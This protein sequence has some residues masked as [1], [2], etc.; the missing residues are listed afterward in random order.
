MC[1]YLRWAP[2]FIKDFTGLLFNLVSFSDQ[3]LFHTLN[4]HY[5]AAISTKIL[6]LLVA[7]FLIGLLSLKIFHYPK[8]VLQFFNIISFIL[9][10]V[11]LM[12]MLSILL[13]KTECVYEGSLHPLFFSSKDAQLLANPD[14]P[15]DL[16]Y[17]HIIMVYSILFVTC[18]TINL[19]VF[20][21]G[22]VRNAATS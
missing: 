22:L 20:Y 12:Q 2:Q 1:V 6:L 16:S 15:C 4:I 11:L 13:K 9:F 7:A 21:A 8:R 17:F 3:T 14:Q 18:W 10:D 19:A 5:D